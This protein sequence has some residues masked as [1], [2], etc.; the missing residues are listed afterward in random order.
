M[1]AQS[2]YILTIHLQTNGGGG[3]WGWLIFLLGLVALALFLYW[4]RRVGEEDLHASLV[5]EEKFPFATAMS[6]GFRPPQT[7]V[8]PAILGADEA[9]GEHQETDQAINQADDLTRVEGIGRKIADLLQEAGISSYDKLAGSQTETLRSILSIGGAQ[10]Q[11]ADPTT[12]PQQARLLASG[13][14]EELAQLQAQLKSER[15]AT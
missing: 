13:E 6:S 3:P 15:Q 14:M 5:Q 9:H 2:A 7:A 1:S 4:F 8:S 11:L 10:F 12:W